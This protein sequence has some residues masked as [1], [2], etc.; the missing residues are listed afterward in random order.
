MRLFKICYNHDPTL[1]GGDP[2]MYVKSEIILAE[3]KEQALKMCSYPPSE[4]NEDPDNPTPEDFWIV[5]EINMN[6]AQVVLSSC[7]EES[8]F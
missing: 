5:E 2:D 4:M 1:V 6:K 8:L 3:N 7:Y